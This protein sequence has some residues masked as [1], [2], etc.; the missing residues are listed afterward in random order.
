MADDKLVVSTTGKS[1]Y[2][3]VIIEIDGKNYEV[4]PVNRDSLVELDKL[5]EEAKKGDLKAFYRQ[6]EI[7][8]GEQPAIAKLDVRQVLEIILYI[9]KQVIQIRKISTEEKKD[10]R[11]G[12]KVSP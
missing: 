1:L 8:I 7:F 6:L 5:D 10:R 11:P 12:V 9:T 3:P 2:R 4:K